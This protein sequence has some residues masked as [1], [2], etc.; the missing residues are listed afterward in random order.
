M[1]LVPIRDTSTSGWH[2]PPRP[3]VLCWERDILRVRD[4]QSSLHRIIWFWAL[5][6]LTLNNKRVSSKNC[7]KVYTG[8]D[9][10]T[11][12]PPPPTS[13]Q[14]E[15]QCLFKF[16]IMETWALVLHD[17][18]QLNNSYYLIFFFGK[19]AIVNSDKATCIHCLVQWVH[20]VNALDCDFLLWKYQQTFHICFIFF[21]MVFKYVISKQ[22]WNKITP[23][24]KRRW[25]IW[26]R[27]YGIMNFPFKN[28]LITCM[29]WTIYLWYTNT[30]MLF[31]AFYL[32]GVSL[33]MKTDNSYWANFDQTW[34]KTSLNV[35][36]SIYSFPR[37]DLSKI[38]K[39]TIIIFSRSTEINF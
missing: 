33:E 18:D 6:R 1:L 10:E 27:M 12:N 39:N 30:C 16:D 35:G 38:L 8:A 13:K 36:G 20:V 4:E 31:D 19:V 9:L 14:K 24:A 26:C 15:K 37:E 32:R 25:C 7:F 3:F 29:L 2:P 5:V 28:I 34:N 17:D 23:W 22:K 21:Y 11:G